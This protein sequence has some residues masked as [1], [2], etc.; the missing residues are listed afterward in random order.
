VNGSDAG[1]QEDEPPPGPAAAPATAPRPGH[2]AETLPGPD[3]RPGQESESASRRGR[4][5]G[6]IAERVGGAHKAW[7]EAVRGKLILSGQTIADIAELTGYSKSKISELLRGEGLYTTWEIT[8][9]VIH[10]LQIPKWPMR[11]LW[12]AAAREAQK[13]PKWIQDCIEQVALVIG[14]SAPPMD[15]QAFSTTSSPV[16][17]AY[18]GVFVPG[19]QGPARVVDETFDVLWLCWDDILASSDAHN[20][21]WQVLRARVMARAP[22]IDGHPDLRD[23]AFATVA[24]HRTSTEAARFAQVEESLVLFEAI[25]RLPD[26]QLDVIVLRHLCGLDQIATADTLGVPLATVRSD[27]RHAKRGLTA[28]LNPHNPHS[29]FNPPDPPNP[30]APLDAPAHLDHTSD[31]PH[32]PHH[33]TGGTPQ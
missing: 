29:P 33:P 9:S 3:Q 16:Y 24:L 2:P 7:L 17:T 26:N 15:H 21:A 8:C 20:A 4:K 23:A 14:P 6:P 32:H 5:L 10:V 1:Q 12:A 18:A 27:E 22:H 13:K 25:S 28:I 11:R 19:E 31:A 30:T